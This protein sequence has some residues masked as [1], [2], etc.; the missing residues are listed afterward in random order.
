MMFKNIFEIMQ[1][2]TLEDLKELLFKTGYRLES[3]DSYINT[4]RYESIH[5]YLTLMFS[6]TC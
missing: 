4:R 1:D 5:R 3:D 2:Y 6:G